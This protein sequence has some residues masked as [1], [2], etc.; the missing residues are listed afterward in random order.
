[1]DLA[2]DNDDYDPMTVEGFEPAEFSDTEK[3]LREGIPLYVPEPEDE[4][5]YALLEF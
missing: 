1:L 5:G 2:N 3:M 4:K